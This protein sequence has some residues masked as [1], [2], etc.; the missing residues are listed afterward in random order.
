MGESTEHFYFIRSQFQRNSIPAKAKL[1]ILERYP[2]EE[3]VVAWNGA[4][5]VKTLFKARQFD[6]LAASNS[7]G[8][9]VLRERGGTIYRLHLVEPSG[10]IVATSKWY[11]YS[12]DRGPLGLAFFPREQIIVV[13]ENEGTRIF[14]IDMKS[15]KYLPNEIPL[16]VDMNQRCLVTAKDS[17]FCDLRWYDS[18]FRQIKQ[19]TGDFQR[20]FLSV[21]NKLL[22]FRNDDGV[23]SI[24]SIEG[25][26]RKVIIKGIDPAIDPFMPL[27][28]IQGYKLQDDGLLLGTLTPSSSGGNYHTHFVNLRTGRATFLMKG[29]CFGS[30]SIDKQ[31]AIAPREWVG[32]YKRGGAKV[33]SLYMMDPKSRK[34]VPVSSPLGQVTDGCW[35]TTY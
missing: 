25:E 8:K 33:G 28:M 1:D 27:T 14:D 11:S 24:T 13:E 16:I 20:P 9:I 30:G 34:Q 19:L 26:H 22:D 7:A 21:E 3:L 35:M 4:A 2:Y 6:K 18:N 15:M 29:K 31:I 10:N 12:Y 5:P 17:S 23:F 32:P